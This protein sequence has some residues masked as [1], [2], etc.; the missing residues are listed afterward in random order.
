MKDLPKIIR[1]NYHELNRYLTQKS[2]GYSSLINLI[3]INVY[4]ND[5]NINMF[6]NFIKT[7]ILSR[8][9]EGYP[10]LDTAC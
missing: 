5:G 3:K 1:M 8:E 2:N 9:R 10:T 4:H 7:Y 6:N